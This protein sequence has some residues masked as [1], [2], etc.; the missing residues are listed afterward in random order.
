MTPTVDVTTE[1]NHLEITLSFEYPITPS[2]LEQAYL[3][4]KSEVGQ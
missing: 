3:V 4:V 1:D 2:D